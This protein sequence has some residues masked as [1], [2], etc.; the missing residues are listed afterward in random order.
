MSTNMN[1]INQHPIEAES[2]RILSEILGDR[3]FDND[4]ELIVKR[5]IHTT[6]DFEFAD[7]VIASEGAVRGAKKALNEGAYIYTDTSMVKAGINKRI[8]ANLGG[9]VECYIADEDVAKLARERGVTR[10]TVAMEKA[11]KDERIKIFA[12]GNA[13]TALIR[14]CEHIEAGEAR[15]DLV[16]G[17]PVGFVNVIES[18]EMLKKMNV[19]Y[20]II[21]GR[22]GGS[23]IAAAIVNA[24]LYMDLK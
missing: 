22:K 7:L 8:I 19:P 10:S 17:A 2:F 1:S 14:L 12:I 18:K 13:P 15:P 5:V 11:V 23:N 9:G 21:D 24:I 4:L 16:I 3:T 6:A 20:I